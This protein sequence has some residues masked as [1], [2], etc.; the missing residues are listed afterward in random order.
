M[1][2][3]IDEKI[4]ALRPEMTRRF[5]AIGGALTGLRLKLPDLLREEHTA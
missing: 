3:Q 4:G 1:Q 2:G 5:H